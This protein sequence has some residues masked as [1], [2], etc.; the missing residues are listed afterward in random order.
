MA[1]R[2]STPGGH[3]LRNRPKTPLRPAKA[4]LRLR[5]ALRAFLESERDVL[6]RANSLLKCIAQ[7]MECAPVA[8]GPF[9]PDV[10]ELATELLERGVA[11]L[12]ELLLD[13][14]LPAVS[15]GASADSEVVT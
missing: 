13:G 12:D 15:V 5:G 14:R 10:L 6:V 7:A 3:A 9:Y 1:I 4:P 2:H 8:T 11:N